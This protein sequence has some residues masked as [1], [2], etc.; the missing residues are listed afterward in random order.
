MD[1]RMCINCWFYN[2]QDLNV[3]QTS[4]VPEA[5]GIKLLFQKTDPPWRQQ[6]K[7]ALGKLAKFLLISSWQVDIISFFPLR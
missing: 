4:S 1:F 5:H 6:K 2:A 7:K 3:L